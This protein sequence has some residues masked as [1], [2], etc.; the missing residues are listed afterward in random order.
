[1]SP[2]C[3]LSC[4]LPFELGLD[5]CD[6]LGFVGVDFPLVA[7]ESSFIVVSVH[8]SGR[9]SRSRAKIPRQKWTRFKKKHYVIVIYCNALF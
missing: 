5:W 1:M 7:T 2:Y 9:P 4:V 3:L 6:V 8:L